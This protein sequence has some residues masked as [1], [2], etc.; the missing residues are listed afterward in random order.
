VLLALPGL[1]VEQHRLELGEALVYG[2]QLGLHLG[3]GAG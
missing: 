1:Q 3:W 2:V